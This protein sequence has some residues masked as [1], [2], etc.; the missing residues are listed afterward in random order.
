MCVFVLAG[1]WGLG[2]GYQKMER[3]CPVLWGWAGRDLVVLK[4]KLVY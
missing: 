3:L 1:G 4:R 2:A